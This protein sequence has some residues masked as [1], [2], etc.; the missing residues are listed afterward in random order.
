M[1]AGVKYS[2]AKPL[3]QITYTNADQQIKNY[4]T[5]QPSR[6]QSPLVQLA[7]KLSVSIS[8]CFD[9]EQF[10]EIITFASVNSDGCLQ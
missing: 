3:A 7:V 4:Q 10:D 2:G 5:Y 1:T 8:F 6:L 9:M